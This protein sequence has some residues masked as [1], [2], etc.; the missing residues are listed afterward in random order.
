MNT[1]TEIMKAL[2]YFFKFL[3]LFFLGGASSIRGSCDLGI[4]RC[5]SVLLSIAAKNID[6]LYNLFSKSF[7]AS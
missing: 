6:I 7:C 5:C 2:T 4:G 1:K 3:F